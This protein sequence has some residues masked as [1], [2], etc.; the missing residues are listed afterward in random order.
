[1]RIASH[2]SQAVYGALGSVHL[3]SGRAGLFRAL[4]VCTKP[5][6]RGGARVVRCAALGSRQ[7]RSSTTAT[8]VFRRRA[9][10]RAGAT[11]N[12]SP[13]ACSY[14]DAA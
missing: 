5:H 7:A 11:A 13:P 8:L 2:H 14:R 1:M 10:N 3:A 9:N 4:E 12:Q 6:R